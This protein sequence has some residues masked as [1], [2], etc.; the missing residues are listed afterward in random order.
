MEYQNTQMLRIREVCQRTSLSKSQIY[1]LV[2]ELGFPAPVRLG[3]RAC[4][5]IESE[6]EEWLQKRITDSRTE[7]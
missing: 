6:V 1:R 5:F 3:K 4:A 2:D 7:D